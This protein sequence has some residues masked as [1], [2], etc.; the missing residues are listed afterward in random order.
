ME[1]KNSEEYIDILSSDGKSFRVLKCGLFSVI[2]PEE[3]LPIHSSYFEFMQSDLDTFKFDIQDSEIIKICQLF[4]SFSTDL[5]DQI[6]KSNLYKFLKQSIGD[7]IIL[8]CEISES[9]IFDL[10][11]NHAPNKECTKFAFIPSKKIKFSRIEKKYKSNFFDCILDFVNS[12]NENENFNDFLDKVKEF[13][14]SKIVRYLIIE[15]M[16]ARFKTLEKINEM[17]FSKK[18]E[19]K[20]LPEGGYE[21]RIGMNM[22]NNNFW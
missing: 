5:Y 3:R 7:Y 4:S 2:N 1:Y 13:L 6:I 22:Y 19:Y 21:Y 9:E 17:A 18:G 10:C 12:A 15:N 8:N 11:V 16:Q 20:F 14:N